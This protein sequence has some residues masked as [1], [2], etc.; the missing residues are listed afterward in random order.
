M[1]CLGLDWGKRKLGLAFGDDRIKI[2]TPFKILRFKTYSEAM[3]LLRKIVEEEVI[4]LIV[5][6]KP[7]NLAGQEFVSQ[8]FERFM[9]ELSKLKIPTSFV[10]E[11]LSTKLAVKKNLE[12]SKHQSRS[13]DDLAAAEI[14]QAYFDRN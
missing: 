14:L 7:R 5:L 12:R 3:E 10:D 1:N 13:D 9:E 2:A 11:R 4:D 8:D 6:G